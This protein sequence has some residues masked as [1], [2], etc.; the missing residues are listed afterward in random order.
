VTKP[1]GPTIPRR[2]LGQ[3]L[4]RLR[5]R[6]GHSQAHIAD[7]LGCSISKIQKIEAG[8]VGI[9][10]AELLMMLDVYGSTAEPVR[11]ELLELQRLGKQRGW[12]SRYGQVPA[13]VAA[14]LGLESAATSIEAFEPLVVHGLL[15][16]EAYARALAQTCEVGPT[17]EDVERQVGILRERQERVFGPNPPRLRVA[18]DEAV[19]RRQIG[20]PQVMAEQLRHLAG[21][22]KRVTVQIVPLSRGGHPGLRGPLTIFGFDDHMHSPVAYAESQA[23]SL[24]VDKDDD[25]QRCR[26]VFEH[27]SAVTL[28][29]Q[30]TVRLLNAMAR[31][32]AG[33]GSVAS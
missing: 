6:A 20:S 5:E 17:G 10:R 7:R 27:L 13:P 23:G 32:F 15:Q 28:G 1:I 26:L 14:F 29:K 33:A 31:E 8:D 30:E 9:V 22:V 2:R 25:V 11:A 19:L 21:L 16:T 12:W 3:Q 24:Y 4:A 18:L